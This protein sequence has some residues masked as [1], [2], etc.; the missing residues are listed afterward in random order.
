MGGLYDDLEEFVQDH[1]PH[2]S[3]S[4]NATTLPL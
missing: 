2:G 4:A 3:L 1:R